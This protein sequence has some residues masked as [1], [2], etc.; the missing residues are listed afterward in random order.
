MIAFRPASLR[1]GTFPPAPSHASFVEW[2][3]AEVDRVVA[4]VQSRLG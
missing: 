2:L 4:L 1:T 3:E